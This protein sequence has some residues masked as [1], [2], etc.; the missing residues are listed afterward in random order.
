MEPSIEKE[1]PRADLAE[2][3]E[4]ESK[5]SGYFADEYRKSSMYWSSLCDVM[6]LNDGP[7][8][9][10]LSY[11]AG[12][13]EADRVNTAA[14]FANAD[15]LFDEKKGATKLRHDKI[16]HEEQKAKT[17]GVTAS[18]DVELLVAGGPEKEAPTNNAVKAI[19]EMA[20]MDCRAARNRDALC[21]ELEHEDML[22]KVKVMGKEMQRRFKELS[23]EGTACLL[24][25][26]N[27]DKR[28][29][30]AFLHLKET[31][32]D[33]VGGKTLHEDVWF[34]FCSYQT[35]V[36][37]QKEAWD[38]VTAKL[39][40]VFAKMK[41]LEGERRTTLREFMLSANRAI[42]DNWKTLCTLPG[43]ASD[44]ATAV[45]ANRGAVDQ[46]VHSLAAVR[47]EEKKHETSKEHVLANTT[48]IVRADPA[49]A[50]D[51]FIET[52]SAPLESPLVRKMMMIERREGK[53]IGSKYYA[54]LM[55]LSWDGFLHFFDIPSSS[56][57]KRD[58][59]ASAAFQEI[60]P[61]ISLDDLLANKKDLDEVLMFK[62]THTLWFDESSTVEAK[63]SHKS[64]KIEVKGRT[65]ITSIK[66][67]FG[68]G[69]TSKTVTFRTA[70]E[71]EMNNIVEEITDC[72]YTRGGMQTAVTGRMS[73]DSRS[74]FG[75][76]FSS[77]GSGSTKLATAQRTG[78][79]AGCPGAH[80]GPLVNGS[81]SR[82]RP[83]RR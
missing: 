13:L 17:K 30:Q 14:I 24:S 59:S 26:A 70:T 42:G 27:I 33:Q 39:G 69:T 75:S 54:G 64:H 9:Q 31:L 52:L 1:L 22:G 60:S 53:A 6:S 79:R 11:V 20:E 57:V 76:S 15:K 73:T 66:R 38:A 23:E 67:H 34:L 81:A 2:I 25:L 55:V 12:K 28:V 35:A 43:P 58:A 62:S 29:G 63:S 65:N 83:R 19:W 56:T 3:E 82:R 36:V 4:F 50:D 7:T 49:P 40:E 37:H 80:S 47:M 74:S 68:S 78:T 16:R 5:R 44:A 72:I 18:I 41:N 77:T 32:G 51:S 8:Q 10:V 46:E 48:H 21:D 61:S 71:A 45:D